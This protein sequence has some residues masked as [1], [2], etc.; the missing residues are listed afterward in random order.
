HGATAPRGPLT[1]RLTR[2]AVRSTL[3]AVKQTALGS[4]ATTGP[5]RRTGCAASATV[6]QHLHAF[7]LDIMR[8]FQCHLAAGGP[9]LAIGA[10]LPVVARAGLAPGATTRLTMR[11]IE[12]GIAR[13]TLTTSHVQRQRLERQLVQLE[14]DLT[15]RRRWPRIGTG[16]ALGADPGTGANIGVHDFQTQRLLARRYTA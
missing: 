15:P 2:F 3:Y 4:A 16:G 14:A 8:H 1:S 12:A 13:C 11:T 7:D 9:I 5:P 6:E 10:I